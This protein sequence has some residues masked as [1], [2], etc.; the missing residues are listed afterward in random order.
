MSNYV[1]CASCGAEIYKH[2][3]V[4]K[5][6]GTAQHQQVSMKL[7]R[8]RCMATCASCGYGCVLAKSHYGEHLCSCGTRWRK[9]KR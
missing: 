9:E 4:C 5:V 8:R 1:R 3:K 6:C 7:V 2:A